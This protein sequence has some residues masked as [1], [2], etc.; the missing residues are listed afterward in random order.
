M[1]SDRVDLEAQGEAEGSVTFFF[2]RLR[3]GDRTAADELW[4]RYFPRIR[5]LARKTL[6][7]YPQRVSDAD[8]AAQSAFV[9]FFQRA[10]RGDFGED[11]DRQSLWNLLGVITVRKA[12]KQ[13]GREQA[14]K[15]GGGQVRG[16]SDQPGAGSNRALRLDQALGQMPTQ[17]F[18]LRCEEL[19]LMLEGELREIAVLRLFGHTN[20]E[21]AA[22]LQCTERKIQRKLHLIRLKWQHYVD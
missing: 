19:L 22:L 1:D 14:Q 8:D 11:L 18:D 10:E 4:K 2:T 6:S 13:V 5:G 12:M 3:T 21:I 16:E 15:R 9:S 17:E 7:N 20:V